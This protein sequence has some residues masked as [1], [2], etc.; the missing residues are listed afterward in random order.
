LEGRTVPAALLAGNSVTVT[1]NNIR[2][3]DLG[4]DSAS[5]TNAITVT[6][7]GTTKTFPGTVTSIT[8]NGNPG[9]DSVVYI[10]GG[11]SEPL[12]GAPP[13][14]PTFLVT[15][16]DR[17]VTT[18][19]TSSARNSFTLLFQPA[20]TFVGAEYDF[21]VNGGAKG[22]NV[23]VRSNGLT[24]DTKSDL[25][26]GFQG[27]G[28]GDNMTVNLVNTAVSPAINPGFAGETPP[29][30]GS[31]AGRN[32]GLGVNVAGRGGN[33]RLFANVSLTDDSQGHIVGQVLGGAGNDLV[34]LIVNLPP[35]LPAVARLT[36]FQQSQPSLMLF[37]G[38]GVN[39]GI[40]TTNVRAG[41]LRSDLVVL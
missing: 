39:T 12:A 37:G 3:V 32:G 29:P 14:S 11:S 1:G 28:G 21:R 33:D 27:T 41:G 24:I 7:D 30:A 15:R 26:L 38:L 36:G 10:L 18:N 9:R 8:I 35:A 34:G 4:T 16:A 31:A 5:V 2:V 19:L 25:N 6:T 40:H 17:T 22:S 13:G 23:A 20:Q